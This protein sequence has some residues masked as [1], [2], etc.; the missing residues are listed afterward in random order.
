MRLSLVAARWRDRAKNAPRA[1]CRARRALSW[2]HSSQYLNQSVHMGFDMGHAAL[3]PSCDG[4]QA[5]CRS[6]R[7]R[8][9]R[10]RGCAQDHTQDSGEQQGTWVMARKRAYYILNAEPLRR[11]SAARGDEDE[12]RAVRTCALMRVS[13]SGSTVSG[14]HWV[15]NETCIQDR[16]IHAIMRRQPCVRQQYTGTL[17]R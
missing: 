1:A 3:M 10:S 4:Q 14:Y 5:R 15:S 9:T 17:C 6:P 11:T 13:V 7:G 12:P 16:S 8:G 2:L